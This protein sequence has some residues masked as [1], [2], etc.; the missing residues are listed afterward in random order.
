MKTVLMKKIESAEKI[1]QL[2][3]GQSVTG[4]TQR[5][6]QRRCDRHAGNH[7]RS[8]VSPR[9]GDD[10]RQSAEES[11]QHV[12]SRRNRA[13]QQ[14]ALRSAQRRNDEI[15]RRGQ[16]AHKHHEAEIAHRT[17]QQVEI[18]DADRQ[19]HAH[20][21]AHQRRNEHRADN[22]G[23]RVD[24]QAQRSYERRENQHPQVRAAKIDP[25]TDIVH[26][27]VL[28]G[29]VLAQIETVPEKAPQR[30]ERR[31]GSVISGHHILWN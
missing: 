14:L 7:G 19:S 3:R 8:P 27:L 26:H 18:V 23:R 17:L 13:R 29:A 11:D 12:V 2:E 10:T 6:H 31:A 15:E 4:R 21:R 28:Q 25:A 20:D 5:R 22:D 16:N 30:V 24:I 9:L 1:I